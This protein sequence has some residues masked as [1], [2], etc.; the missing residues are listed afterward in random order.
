MSDA[1]SRADPERPPGDE[2]TDDER[3]MLEWISE[4]SD[5]LGDLAAAILRQEDASDEVT[6]S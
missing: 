5:R 4:N 3:E 6:R 2:L 1:P